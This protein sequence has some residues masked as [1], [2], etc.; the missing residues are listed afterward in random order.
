MLDHRVY[1]KTLNNTVKCLCHF[2]FHPTMCKNFTCYTPLLT[3]LSIFWILAI[4]VGI[5]LVFLTWWLT[6]NI[7]SNNYWLLSYLILWSNWWGLLHS[8]WLD[9]LIIAMYYFLCSLLWVIYQIHILQI[10]S[11]SLGLLFYFLNSW[12]WVFNFEKWKIFIFS[13]VANAFN[14]CL[15]QGCEDSLPRFLLETFIV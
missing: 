12:A 6:L 3:Q 2:S 14:L 11:S 8:H 4:L 15:L 1:K 9:Y 10:L 13:F 5:Y 7:F